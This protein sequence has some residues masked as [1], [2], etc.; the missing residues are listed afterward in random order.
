MYRLLFI[1][2]S[3]VVNNAFPSAQYRTDA[4]PNISATPGVSLP[5][6][7]LTGRS[8]ATHEYRHTVADGS[9]ST[10]PRVRTR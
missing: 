4:S 5:R 1:D 8:S 3:Q 7:R 10:A 9:S 2:I 6:Y